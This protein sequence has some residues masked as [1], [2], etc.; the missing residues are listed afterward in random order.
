MAIAM[1]R[2]VEE[3]RIS[4]M[5]AVS[6]EANSG[7]NCVRRMNAEKDSMKRSLMSFP[8]CSGISILNL[9]LFGL[10]TVRGPTAI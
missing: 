9:G 8:T 6:T 7:E 5:R 2:N 1:W 3:V 10:G 4:G